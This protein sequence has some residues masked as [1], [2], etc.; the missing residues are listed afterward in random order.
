MAVVRSRSAEIGHAPLDW[1]EPPEK[2]T[3]WARRGYVSIGDSERREVVFFYRVV[4]G[5][6][7][8]ILALPYKNTS[9]PVFI[10]LSLLC[11]LLRQLHLERES[12]EE[13][14][15]ASSIPLLRAHA[16]YGVC[17]VGGNRYCGCIVPLF[18]LFFAARFLF[19]VSSLKM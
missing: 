2:K 6:T 1:S 9:P 12:E 7:T 13:S 18:S 17:F 8:A 16:V 3:K 19:A 4:A 15:G 10:S 14:D 11:C 5:P